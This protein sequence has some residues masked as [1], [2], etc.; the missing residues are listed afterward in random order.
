MSVISY[1]S[2]PKKLKAYR[3]SAIKGREKEHGIE[4]IKWLLQNQL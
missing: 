3:L 4:V 2:F 1:V